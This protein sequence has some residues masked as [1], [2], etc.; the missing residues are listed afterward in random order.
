MW[1]AENRR[2]YDRSKLRYPSDV[3]DAE[4]LVLK[5]HIPRAKRGGNRRHVDAR[6]IVNGLMLSLFLRRFEVQTKTV[7]ASRVAFR[8][9]L[10]DRDNSRLAIAQPRGDELRGQSRFSRARRASDEETVTF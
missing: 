5:P 2:R 3:T 10:E 7:G 9:F 4:W 8:A 6:E 1:T